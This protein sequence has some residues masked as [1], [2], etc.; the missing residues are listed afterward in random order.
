MKTIFKLFLSSALILIHPP[1]SAG[2]FTGNGGDHTRG[3]FLKMGGAVS[4]FLQQTQ[5]G[6]RLLA[7]N[8]INLTD[9]QKLL[10]I[11][12]VSTVEND[13]I[14]NGGSAVDAIGEKGKIVL[15]KTRW[16]E[17]FEKERDVYYLVFHELL[18]A[19]GTN[20]DN[21]ALSKALLPFPTSR[22]IS[23]RITPI[24]PLIDSERLDRAFQLDR[25]SV[26]GSGCP[27]EN[28]RTRVDFDRETNQLEIAFEEYILP[29]NK[30]SHGLFSRKS[31]G[32]AIPITLPEN[33]RLVVTQMDL[34]AHLD[35]SAN[36][37]LEF[38]AEVFFA[39][40]TNLRL[41]QTVN[42][43]TVPQKGRSLLR[44][45]E[46]LKS[47]CGGNGIFRTNSFATHRRTNTIES[48]MAALSNFKL[49]FKIEKC[50]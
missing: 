10:N 17:H 33:T 23:T 5:E 42:G 50:P 24:Y 7:D 41:T 20:D 2:H 34:A 9:L 29:L 49:S 27:Q 37:N 35:L 18:R 44:R 36:S 4:E 12:I 19:H 43:Q 16:M 46:V 48:S 22:K 15:N 25:I 11:E 14:D 39:G 21:Y 8:N 26:H 47:A 6:Q 31:C 40:E 32:L 13:L 38:G 45:N 1:V 30:E 3:L 28:F